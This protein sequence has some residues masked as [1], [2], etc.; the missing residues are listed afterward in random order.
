MLTQGDDY[1]IHQTAE[2]IAFSGTDR[3]FYDR[4]FFNG[5]QTD[6]S[7]F[8]A[9]A[10]GVYPHLNVA[11]AHLSFIRDGVQHCLHASRLLAMERMDLSVGP[12]RIEIVEPLNILRIVVIEHEGISADLT[13]T[14]RAFPVE[15]PR[16]TRRIGPRTFMDY[17]RM[18]QNGHWSGWIEKDGVREDVTGSV[19]TRDRSW[20]I[21]PI[22]ASDPQPNVP[23]Q[24]PQFFWL[25]SP[26]NFA[27]ASLFFHINADQAGKPWNSRAVWC[28]DKA[29]PAEQIETE[30]A[31]MSLTLIPGWRHASSANLSIEAEGQPAREATFQPLT[32]FLMRG[33]GYGHPTWGHGGW[34]GELVVEREDIDLSAITPGRPDHLHI[35]AVCKVTLSTGGETQVGTGI[36]EQFIIGAYAP[37]GLTSLVAD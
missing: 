23:Q 26:V 17:T 14:G 31:S 29:G 8:F 10:F 18:T 13:F 24:V 5:Y 28:P 16:F 7:G 3:N 25:W 35:Q 33:L 15:E 9:V 11:D 20:G 22:G 2:P 1:P 34:K 21:R 30:R 19:G 27:D 4:Y 36:L 32:T 6:G 37:L 12:I